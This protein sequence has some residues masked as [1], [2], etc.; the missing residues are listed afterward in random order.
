[1]PLLTPFGKMG[2]EQVMYARPSPLEVR[3][4]AIEQSEMWAVVVSG[5]E[6][7]VII[8]NKPG[9]IRSKGACSTCKENEWVDTGGLSQ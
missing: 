8:M 3:Q 4:H 6:E 7:K 9:L 1:M 2:L 5:C